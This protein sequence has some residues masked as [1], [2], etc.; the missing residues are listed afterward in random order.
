MG[1]KFQLRKNK[2]IL[3]SGEHISLTKEMIQ[4]FSLRGRESLEEE[5]YEAL[6]RYRMKLSAYSWLSK[7]D[8]AAKELELKLLHCYG[9]KD[10]VSS[11]LEELL[12]Q[13]YLNDK[14]F[15]LQWISSKKYSQR[16]IE[17]LLLQ[18]G[19]SR[20]IIREAI[21]EVAQDPSEEIQRIWEKLGNKEKEKKIM[22]LLRKGYNYSEIQKAISEKE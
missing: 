12:Q 20:E 7:R 8:Y 22:A 18:K 4:K 3:E 21:Q 1:K 5:E 11:L 9:H 6:I 13:G 15:A 17:Y 16:K 19:L 10:W 14:N 2:M